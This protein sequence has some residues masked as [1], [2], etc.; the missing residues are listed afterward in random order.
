MWG[1][2]STVNVLAEL[3]ENDPDGFGEVCCQI[4]EAYMFYY[5]IGVEKDKYATAAQ[6]FQYAT[7]NHAVAKIY[8]DISECLQNITKFSKAEQYANLYNE[9]ISLWDKVQVLRT[10]AANYDDDLKL[11]V[12]KEL[13]NMIQ[14]NAKEFCEVSDQN[15]IVRFLDSIKAD[16]TQI[17]NSFLQ[18]SISSLGSTIETTKTKIQSVKADAKTE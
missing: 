10:D 5:E 2:S 12:W 4:G 13:V 17:T 7:D 1:Y 8:C 15:E 18:E 11:R 9:Y 3:S 16:S 6:W 14:N